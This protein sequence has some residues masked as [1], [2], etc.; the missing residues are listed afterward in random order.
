M[1]NSLSLSTGDTPV[2]DES[3]SLWLTF[4]WPASECF[5]TVNEQI[6]SCGLE[7]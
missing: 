6:N 4:A 1:R 2:E 7:F 3:T 5:V